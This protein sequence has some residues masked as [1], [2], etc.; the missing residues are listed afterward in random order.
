MASYFKI[1]PAAQILVNIKLVFWR[2][3]RV[4]FSQAL[5]QNV[6]LREDLLKTA[7]HVKKGNT[8]VKTIITKVFE[9]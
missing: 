2:V 5:T 9:K 6:K 4:L 1:L 3:W 7:D 8:V